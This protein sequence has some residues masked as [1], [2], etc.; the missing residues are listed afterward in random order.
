MNKDEE[1][2]ISM[3]YH[4]NKWQNKWYKKGMDLSLTLL[5]LITADV[6]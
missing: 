6:F 3:W 5:N 4:Y 2:D 1:T